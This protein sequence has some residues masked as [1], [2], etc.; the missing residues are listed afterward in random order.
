MKASTRI[1]GAGAWLTL[2]F[3]ASQLF[4]LV[5]Q[6]GTTWT[7][8]PGGIRVIALLLFMTVFVGL[9]AILSL[10]ALFGQPKGLY[11]KFSA[12]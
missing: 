3:A 8:G 10:F 11:K 7:N 6:I 5:R 12:N 9:P 4:G 2:A 1:I